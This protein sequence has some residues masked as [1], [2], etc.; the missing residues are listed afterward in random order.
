[1][2]IAMEEADL[3]GVLNYFA[4]ELNQICLSILKVQSYVYKV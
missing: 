4:S 3:K 2:L 1:M